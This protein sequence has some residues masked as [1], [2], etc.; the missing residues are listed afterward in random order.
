MTTGNSTPETV[1]VLGVGRRVDNIEQKHIDPLQARLFEEM[2][3]SRESFEVIE[4]LFNPLEDLHTAIIAKQEFLRLQLWLGEDRLDADDVEALADH[5]ADELAASPRRRSVDTLPVDFHRWGDGSK[6]VLSIAPSIGVVAERS[7]AQRAIMEF[8]HLE[9]EDMPGNIWYTDPH[10]ATRVWLARSYN[11]E[12][13]ALLTRL[14]GLIAEGI[15][16][17]DPRPSMPAKTKLGKIE[18]LPSEKEVPKRRRRSKAISPDA[19][20]AA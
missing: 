9:I 13:V 3:G 16:K 14:G 20:P 18:T 2:G 10:K 4:G 1:P 5:V 19:T 17:G 6:Y 7:V 8:L 11:A 12:E 15:E